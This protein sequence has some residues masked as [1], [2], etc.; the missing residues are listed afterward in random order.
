MKHTKHLQQ[1]MNNFTRLLKLVI[2]LITMGFYNQ[3]VKAQC[4]AFF[5]D[6]LLSNG[7]VHFSSIGSSPSLTY[8]WNFGDS[9]TGTGL[10]VIHT[11][12]YNSTF[13]VAL[14]ING[15]DS[16]T[17]LPCKDTA[18][19]TIVVSNVGVGCNINP[20]LSYQNGPNGLV[21]FSA[22]SSFG[23]AVSYTWNFGDGSSALGNNVNHTYTVNDT[24]TVKLFS[25]I[26]GTTCADT[27]SQIL[28][29]T[30]T[31]VNPCNI[32]P[33]FS[34]IYG[35]AGLVSF[36]DSSIGVFPNVQ[37]TWYFGDGNV[38]VGKNVNHT[39]ASN[40][41]YNVK[42]KIVTYDSVTFTSCYDSISN[43]VTITNVVPSLC[44]LQSYFY[45][46]YG[47]GGGVSFYDG[48]SG[49]GSSTTYSWSFGD[50]NSDTGVVTGHVYAS[51]GLYQVSLVTTTIDSGSGA[52]CIDSSF[53]TLVITN[54]GTP[55]CSASFVSSKNPSGSYTFT[56][57][58]NGTLST[59]QYNW[60]FG[61]GSNSS[62]ASPTHLYT[63][64]GLY[65]VTLIITST[66]T[67]TGFVCTDSISQQDTINISQV[68]CNLT[69]NYY[70]IYNQAGAI[71]FFNGS[72]GATPY[73]T[74]AWNFGDGQSGTGKQVGHYYLL[75]TA[76]QVTMIATTIDPSTGIACIDTV[77][78]MVT[79]SNAPPIPN[80]VASFTYAI[81]STGAYV[82]TSTS[83][84]IIT[85]GTIYSWSFGDGTPASYSPSHIYTNNGTYNITLI[86]TC[87]NGFSGATLCTD[88]ITQTVVVINAG[89]ALCTATAAFQMVPDS[90][91]L[92]T[93]TAFP[94]YTPS[95]ASAA[96]HWG[97]G[98]STVGF[99][100]SHTYA[101]PGVYNICLIV[102]D[103]CGAMDTACMVSNIFK[104][105]NSAVIYIVNVV[106][107]LTPLAVKKV[108]KT[109][110]T[111][112]IYP[113][114]STGIFNLSFSNE[115]KNVKMEVS[116]VLGRKIISMKLNNEKSIDLSELKNGTYYVSFIAND[117][118]FRDKIIIQ[119]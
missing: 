15:F 101:A 64:N 107:N 28:I 20:I 66:D 87:I 50:G 16:L 22:F 12:T 80:C 24:F 59:T 85:P 93:W 77:I 37:Y 108:V 90:S 6:T 19:K 27:A 70:Y 23:S 72:T 102:T 42:L 57:T 3:K 45:F 26:S 21:S 39:Y 114:P 82:C 79:V 40:G 73:T 119:K 116:D 8:T 97:D 95:T 69:A 5:V 41:N 7:N 53:Q 67:L 30:N 49:L 115:I 47:A 58:S 34:S 91:A 103:T 83:T 51:N 52:L 94:I 89:P 76:Y 104:G 105:T 43:V 62:V 18:Y 46:L 1:Y 25:Y 99:N 2:V 44:N 110:L 100:P 68:P 9:L 65:I 86:I 10:N 75:N 55:S 38:N 11:Y 60:N 81:D 74:Y 29:I 48:S 35:A 118:I 61:D 113:N 117:K 111:F 78:K 112:N 31:G 63:S 54:V 71:G 14:Y 98:S 56:N 33:N 4:N 109:D 13:T 88:S 92:L 96:W 84:G 36:S 32:T 106:P 17:G